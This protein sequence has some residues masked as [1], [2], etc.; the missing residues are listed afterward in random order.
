M[1]A[2][3]QTSIKTVETVLVELYSDGFVRSYA[4][5]NVNIIIINRPHA[6]TLEGGMLAEQLIDDILPFNFK[7]VYFPG[8]IRAT[9]QLK[10]VTPTSI[11]RRLERIDLLHSLNFSGDAWRKP[12]LGRARFSAG[13]W[14]QNL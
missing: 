6:A 14:G 4:S 10:R 1:N 8:M 9:G 7:A 5:K 2:P 3:R 12:H 13:F 11:K